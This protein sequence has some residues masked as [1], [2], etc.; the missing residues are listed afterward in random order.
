MQKS[1]LS[2]SLNARFLEALKLRMWTANGA[3]LFGRIGFCYMLNTLVL[4]CS[5]S[6]V[7]LWVKIASAAAIH[8][9]FCT[10]DIN[11]KHGL[12]NYKAWYTALTLKN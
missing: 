2:T 11:I 8:V 1:L 12:L 10:P 7:S 9:L 3:K 6:M 4:A 5:L